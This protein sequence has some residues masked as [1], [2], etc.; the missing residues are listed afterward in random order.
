MKK[1]F[2]FIS[3]L[4]AV[5]NLMA[6]PIGEKR[7]RE[8]AMEFFAQRMTRSAIGELELE[9]AG[10][11][12]NTVTRTGSNLDDSLMYIY[13]S[14]ASDSFVIVGGDTNADLVIAYSLDNTFDMENMADATKAILNAWC[15][16]IEDARK[17]KYVV[18]YAKYQGTRASS[19]VLYQTAEWGQDEPYN[20]E[21]PEYGG[22]RSVTGCAATAMSIICHYNKWPSAGVGTTPEYSYEDYN[23]TIRTIPA[24]KLG[25]TY[26]YNNM[27]MSYEGNYTQAQGDAVAALMKDTG[28]A[29]QMEYMSVMLENGQTESSAKSDMAVKAFTEHFRYSRNAQLVYGDIYHYDE[30]CNILQENI[31]KYGPTFFAGFSGPNSGHAFIV[32]GFNADNYFHFNFGW[33]GDYNAFYFLPDIPYSINQCAILYLSPDRD[34]TSQYCDNLKLYY[35][36]TKD[37]IK[38]IET[39]QTTYSQGTPFACGITFI[40]NYGETTFNGCIKLVLCDKNGNW[41]QE[42]WSMDTSIKSGYHLS[43]E[44]YLEDCAFNIALNEGDRLRVYYKG[45]YSDDWQWARRDDERISD[46]VLVVASPEDMAEGFSFIYDKDTQIMAFKNNHSMRIEIYDL[47]NNQDLGYAEMTP[48]YECEYPITTGITY[49]FEVSLGSDPYELILKF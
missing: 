44:T 34:N 48:R 9:W 16:Q 47:T 39:N 25:H 2:L 22:I 40:A 23:K 15:R 45:E 14:N 5:T 37:Y 42:I 41:K 20:L 21:A 10:N 13:N 32:D 8:I 3:L 17:G 29:L 43:K 19:E 26:D 4:F 35:D 36:D 24:N 38:G 46:E 27:L 33:N 30:W 1:I 31:K 28:T 7:A 49:K 12:I 18:D 6:E 11:S